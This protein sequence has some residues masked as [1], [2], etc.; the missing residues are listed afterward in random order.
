[1]GSNGNKRQRTCR[2]SFG[3]LPAGLNMAERGP[4]PAWPLIP[5]P[6]DDTR[7]REYSSSKPRIDDQ[8]FNRYSLLKTSGVIY[9]K[10]FK[11]HRR[12]STTS[13]YCLVCLKYSRI[14]SAADK[15]VGDSNA[16][17]YRFTKLAKVTSS[18]IIDHLQS[19]L[20]SPINRISSNETS[21]NFWSHWVR[22]S[23]TRGSAKP[24]SKTVNLSNWLVLIVQL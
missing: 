4:Q 10:H 13:L 9:W 17:V 24:L 8:R 7:G 5:P 19:N 20:A 22:Y 23:F 6:D 2:P 12:Q 15:T 3:S 21:A 14:E 1:M 16:R 11:C 18:T